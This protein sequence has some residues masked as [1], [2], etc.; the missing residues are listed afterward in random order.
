MRT[1][2]FPDC[3]CCKTLIVPTPLSFHCLLAF[4]NRNSF[5]LW[6][7]MTLSSSS[8]LLRSTTS[9]RL[10]TGVNSA[11]V[12]KDVLSASSLYSETLGGFIGSGSRGGLLMTG[13]EVARSAFSQEE[14]KENE[15]ASLGTVA[16]ASAALTGALRETEIAEKDEAKVAVDVLDGGKPCEPKSGG[17]LADVVLLLRAAG[18]GGRKM[19]DDSEPEPKGDVM[20]AVDTSVSA[21][22]AMLW[23][24]DVLPTVECSWVNGLVAGSANKLDAVET[25]PTED[26]LRAV[27]ILARTSV[28]SVVGMFWKSGIL[29]A[30]E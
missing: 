18:A 26:T 9:G 17:T 20:M 16:L 7:K 3:V 2:N 11:L 15:G 25:K 12:L 29:P 8:P 28:E 24:G 19:L 10:T 13:V 5:A 21:L 6:A 1:R 4:S 22:A 14:E 30:V 27:D 23:E